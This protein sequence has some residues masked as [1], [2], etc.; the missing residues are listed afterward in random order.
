MKK[1]LLIS[2]NENKIEEYRFQFR[3]Y[4]IEIDAMPWDRDDEAL[5]NNIKAH[6]QETLNGIG[7]PNAAVYAL[8]EWSTLYNAETHKPST[9]TEDMEQVYN[10]GELI[11][12]CLDGKGQFSAQH[13][14]HIVYGYLDLS[15]KET[16]GFDWDRIFVNAIT[17]KTYGESIPLWGKCSP[18]QLL[19]SDFIQQ[20][21][22]YKKPK[23]LKF[24]DYK[25]EETIVFASLSEELNKNPLFRDNLKNHRLDHFIGHAINDG[26]HLRFAK[27]RRE[28]NYWLPGLNGGLPAVSKPDI[29]HETTYRFHDLVHYALAPA[30]DV[31]PTDD[32]GPE[33]HRVY[34]AAR[35]ASE[36]ISLVMAD[37][38]FVDN[39]KK[40]GEPYDY[41]ARNIYPVFEQ[42]K[43][44]GDLKAIC[45]ASTCYAL[46]GDIEPLRALMREGDATDAALGNFTEWYSRFFSADNVWTQANF[47][48]LSKQGGLY[49]KWHDTL[50]RDLF[51]RANIDTLPE[52]TDRIKSAG[53]DMSSYQDIVYAVFD[54]IFENHVTPRLQQAPAKLSPEQEISNAFRRYMMGQA[55]FY[56]RYEALPGMAARGNRIITALREKEFFSGEDITQLRKEFK[57]DVMFANAAHV[58]T[59][60]DCRIF[61]Q[62]FP[63]FP[64]VYLAGYDK[65]DKDIK[66]AIATIFPETT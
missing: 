29:V 11:I 25:P 54:H 57:K 53:T 5:E 33:A 24:S 30:C 35:M 59:H 64:P 27:N 14:E 60:D 51:R 28:N 4:G 46:L 31:V 3:Q 38:L 7:K 47:A 16:A 58:I 17:G 9:L 13:K 8:N 48:N 56:I 6:L 45:K 49:K 65:Q 26:I 32:F 42:L 12:Y 19:I 43:D 63:V 1:I 55:L 62:I 40:S 39:L 36:A 20:Y 21:I 66:A 10:K 2:G 23:N 50:G 37:M 44:T 34:H 15:R 41:G 18:R 22:F 52:M 61:T